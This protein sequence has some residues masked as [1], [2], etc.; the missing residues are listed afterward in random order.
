[1]AGLQN[2]PRHRRK[3]QNHKPCDHQPVSQKRQGNPHAEGEKSHQTPL[4]PQKPYP[5][6]RTF[7]SSE[8]RK[9]PSF[10]QI[11][12]VHHCGQSTRGQYVHT[13]TV[14]DVASNWTRTK[15]HVRLLRDGVKWTEQGRNPVP[16]RIGTGKR[17]P[18]QR[19]G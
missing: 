3:T 16:F 10:W 13:L 2:Y 15:V 6:I 7:Y 4:F 12:T 11:D 17:K 5:P 19:M 14:T 9:T 8:E 18:P 1:M